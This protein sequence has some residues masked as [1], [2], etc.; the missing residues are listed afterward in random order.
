MSNLSYLEEELDKKME[1]IQEARYF[2]N[3]LKEQDY[4]DEAEMNVLQEDLL[5]VLKDL[6]MGE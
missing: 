5:L 1:A 2:I 6:G 4:K 3:R